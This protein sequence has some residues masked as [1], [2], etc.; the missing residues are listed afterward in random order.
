[1]VICLHLKHVLLSAN[2]FVIAI[3]SSQNEFNDPCSSASFSILRAKFWKVVIKC[4]IIMFIK[5]WAF[6][7]KCIFLWLNHFISP[8]ADSINSIFSVVICIHKIHV[9]DEV[10]FLLAT[11]SMITEKMYFF[12]FHDNHS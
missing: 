5:F 6:F 9:F 7:S 1:M 8:S 11:V 2:I 3:C 12:Y 4:N 10:L